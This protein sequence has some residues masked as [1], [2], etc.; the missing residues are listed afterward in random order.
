MSSNFNFSFSNMVPNFRENK[1][2]ANENPNKKTSIKND[3][4]ERLNAVRKSVGDKPDALVKKVMEMVT[5]NPEVNNS[6]AIPLLQ[7][8]ADRLAAINDRAKGPKKTEAQLAEIRILD[9]LD[10]REKL[11]LAQLQAEGARRAA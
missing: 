5:N 6:Q 10:T 11:M 1:P 7:Q 2:E 8:A 4:D 9:A 3:V